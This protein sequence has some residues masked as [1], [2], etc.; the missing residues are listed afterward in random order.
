MRCRV[1]SR[2]NYNL[3]LLLTNIPQ[4]ADARVPLSLGGGGA[5][6]RLYRKCCVPLLVVFPRW[7]VS[8][9]SN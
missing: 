6:I 9:P 1:A 4:K 7:F 8:M 5:Y 2:G 3:V